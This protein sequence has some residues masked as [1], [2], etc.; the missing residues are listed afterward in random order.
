MV[1]LTNQ[2]LQEEHHEARGAPFGGVPGWRSGWRL[3]LEC[4]CRARLVLDGEV[5]L[6]RSRRVLQCGLCGKRF[7]FAGRGV[8]AHDLSAEHLQPQRRKHS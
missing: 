3:V 2:Y 8:D 4:D 1:Q 6:R 7:A 5:A